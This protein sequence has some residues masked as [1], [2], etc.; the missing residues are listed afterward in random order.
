MKKCKHDRVHISG[1]K[2]G[3]CPCGKTHVVECF[4]DLPILVRKAFFEEVKNG[5]F[6][7]DGHTRKWCVQAWNKAIGAYA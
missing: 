3:E 7:D 6:E 5:K 2:R 4:D 1:Q